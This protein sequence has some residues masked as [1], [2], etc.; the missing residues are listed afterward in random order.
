MIFWAGKGFDEQNGTGKIYGAVVSEGDTDS[1]GE[2]HINS[3]YAVNNSS[4][5]APPDATVMSRR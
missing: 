2:F 3:T 1:K 5:Y 4:L